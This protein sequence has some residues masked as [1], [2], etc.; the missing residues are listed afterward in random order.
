MQWLPFSIIIVIREFC[1]QCCNL[2]VSE[3]NGWLET[4]DHTVCIFGTR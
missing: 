2:F 3:R 1:V 4:K